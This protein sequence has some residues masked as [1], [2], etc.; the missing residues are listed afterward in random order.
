MPGAK[1]F[2]DKVKANPT[3]KDAIDIDGLTKDGGD[4]KKLAALAPAI[5]RLKKDAT[6]DPN[7]FK[8]LSTALD[9]APPNIVSGIADDIKQHPEKLADDL[10]GAKK[11]A[12]DAAND[13]FGLG[14]IKSF[15][16]SLGGGLGGRIM[17][18]LSG[19]LDKIVSFFESMLSGPKQGVSNNDFGLAR[20]AGATPPPMSPV[21]PNS[22]ATVRQSVAP[23][24]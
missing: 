5:A 13:P 8:T 21:A 7:F 24:G 22:L 20:Q 14:K 6:D 2:F 3:L 23:G 11:Q 9:N 4:P 1:E 17:N 12:D 15:F 16:D 10:E 19:L 18:V